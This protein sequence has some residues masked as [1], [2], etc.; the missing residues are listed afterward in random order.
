MKKNF[1][2][3][4]LE[5]QLCFEIYLAAKNFDQMY[6]RALREFGLTFPQYLVLLA[7]WEEDAVS[8]K[9]IG[10]SLHMKMGSLNPILTRLE[11]RGWIHKKVSETDRRV[12][13]ISLEQIA[14][15]SKRAIHEAILREVSGSNLWD[16]D[17]QIL[18]KQL[19]AINDRLPPSILESRE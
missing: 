13:I 14:L 5:D 6:K 2:D 8:I 4:R 10:S 12:T 9:R 19:L 3:R 7:L 17:F 15:T 1:F 11:T 16:V 18:M